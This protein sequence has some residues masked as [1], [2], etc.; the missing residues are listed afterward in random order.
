MLQDITKDV[1]NLPTFEVT[2]PAPSFIQKYKIPI[3]IGAALLII[4]AA[5]KSKKHAVR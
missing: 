3:L 5:Y 2:A 1:Q 4:F